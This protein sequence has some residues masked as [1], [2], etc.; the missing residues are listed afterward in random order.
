MSDNEQPVESREDNLLR[1]IK[2][3]REEILELKE[4]NESLWSYMEDQKASTN[5]IGDKLIETVKSQIEEECRRKLKL[6]GEA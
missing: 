4:E 1:T 6:L 3:L 2:T 5:S